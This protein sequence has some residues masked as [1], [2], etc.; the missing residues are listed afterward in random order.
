MIPKLRCAQA[1]PQSG[2]EHRFVIV[3]PTAVVCGREVRLLREETRVL[4]LIGDYV[5]F[6][7]G[8]GRGAR[9]RHIICQLTTELPNLIDQLE[10]KEEDKND[11]TNEDNDNET[12]EDEDEDEDEE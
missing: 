9:I 12:N 4:K 8:D 2:K 10:D 1:S 7:R 11:E 3:V 6:V 5:G